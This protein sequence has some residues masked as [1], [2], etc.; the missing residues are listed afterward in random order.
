MDRKRLLSSLG[1]V[2]K[3]ST[4]LFRA[5]LLEDAWIP[6]LLGL[7]GLL[8]ILTWQLKLITIIPILKM[9]FK[10]IHTVLTQ[11]PMERE[12]GFYDSTTTRIL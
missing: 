9:V 7:F 10:T 4:L 8:R 5:A 1:L 6:L 11:Q 3:S 12:Y 2:I